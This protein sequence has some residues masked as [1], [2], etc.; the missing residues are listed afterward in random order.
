[1][2]VF[3]RKISLIA[4]IAATGI[5]LF[6]F[7]NC[8]PP[9]SSGGFESSTAGLSGQISPS[10]F[11][12]SQT[13]Q[14]GRCGPGINLCDEGVYVNEPDTDLSVW[15]CVGTG[16]GSSVRCTSNFSNAPVPGIC[17][18]LKNQCLQG[19]LVDVADPAPDSPKWECHG[20]NGGA[21]D[22]CQIVP[23]PYTPPTTGVCGT[24]PY[25]CSPGLVVRN[26]TPPP[27]S[28]D[29]YWT[30]NGL[31]GGAP[32]GVCRYSNSDPNAPVCGTTEMSCVNSTAVDVSDTDSNFAWQC[33]KAGYAP[34][35]CLASKPVCLL[36][37]EP[38]THYNDNYNLRVNVTAGS[39][40]SSVTVK[41][42]GTKSTMAGTGTASLATETLLNVRTTPLNIPKTNTG[43]AVA[44]VYN[45]WLTVEKNNKELCRTNP[46]EYTL[47]PRCDLSFDKTTL[48]TTETLVATF[49]FAVPEEI[50]LASTPYYIT[51][52]GTKDGV[53]DETGLNTATVVLAGGVANRSVGPLAAG[54][55]ER[56][57]IA[58]AS[59]SLGSKQL[60]KSTKKTFTVSA[61]AAVDGVCSDANHPL[62]TDT[63]AVG[64]P[65]DTGAAGDSADQN[66]WRCQGQGTGLTRSCSTPKAPAITNYC[67]VSTSTN[68][69]ACLTGA[70]ATNTVFNCTTGRYSWNCQVPNTNIS[71]SCEYFGLAN[72]CPV[73]PP[74]DDPTRPGTCSSGETITIQLLDNT[75]REVC[76]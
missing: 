38:L 6:S 33:T 68:R 66:I 24:A 18:S 65:I 4:F 7:Q 30:C 25:S 43:G 14:V 44:G 59:G 17:S 15:S 57:F 2:N 42:H 50:P 61:V 26:I 32:S 13:F 29:D 71:S 21:T 48:S 39:L 63:C 58:T 60:C 69:Y 54:T 74:P 8:A 55:Y 40:P 70:T 47:T 9:K 75:I 35:G 51:W 56:Y 45:R 27:G 31:Y 20:F 53:A 16:G 67:G 76:Q 10:S 28:P 5:A 34:K 1:M 36:A 49:N 46:I 62:A 22:V 3:S 37:V 19:R 41:I 52:F 11:A 23:G 72:S 73:D 12:E 64:T